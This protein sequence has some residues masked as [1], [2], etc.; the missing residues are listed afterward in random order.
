MKAGDTFGAMDDKGQQ[1]Q[2]TIPADVTQEG[3][4]FKYEV[5]QEF[6]VQIPPDAKPGDIVEVDTTR[7]AVAPQVQAPFG[8]SMTFAPGLGGSFTAVAAP[9]P[10]GSFQFPV[11]PAPVQVQA[12]V[13]TAPV[14][15]PVFQKPLLPAEAAIISSSFPAPT[16]IQPIVPA[17]QASVVAAPMGGSVNFPVVAAPMG[18]SVNFSSMPAP[19]VMVS[20]APVMAAPMGGSV[21]FSTMPAPTVM[22]PQV[23]Y[24]AAPMGGSV[25]FPTVPAPAVTAQMVTAPQVPTYTSQPYAAMPFGTSA[26]SAAPV[27]QQYSMQP[28][29]P[30]AAP[31]FAGQP[32]LTGGTMTMGFQPAVSAVNATPF[33]AGSLTYQP[34]GTSGLFGTRST[35]VS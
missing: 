11:A 24:M 28:S 25:N 30:Q 2:V 32:L 12:P 14:Q 20:Q 33:P 17:P 22:A 29:L 9:I 31:Q 35:L 21:D 1:V 16:V 27:V 18:G 8:G 4:T 19:Q 15:A 5:K 26:Y 10:G 7:A 6:Q 3:Q 13:V 34:M 23:P